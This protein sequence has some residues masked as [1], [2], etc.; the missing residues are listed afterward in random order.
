MLGLPQFP[1]AW[2][3]DR[4]QGE[5]QERREAKTPLAKLSETADVFFIITRAQNDG[6]PVRELPPFAI[7]H[8]LIYAY[9]VA[10]LTLRWGFYRVAGYLCKSKGERYEPIREVVNP[11]KNHKLYTVA[12][13]HDVDDEEF[14]QKCIWLRRVWPLL[15]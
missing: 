5:L 7:S 9:M 10:K 3:R 8:L 6:K 1:Q 13:R 14:V 15:P 12:A 2:Y 4:L 11:A